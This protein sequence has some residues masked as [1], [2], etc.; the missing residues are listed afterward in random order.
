MM[1]TF[2]VVTDL[3]GREPSYCAPL[4]ALDEREDLEDMMADWPDREEWFLGEIAYRVATDA[5]RDAAATD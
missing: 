2:M 3:C 5:E 4:S 1:E